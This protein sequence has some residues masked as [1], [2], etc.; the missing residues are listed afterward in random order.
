MISSTNL[1]QSPRVT[2]C[3]LACIV[4]SHQPNFPLPQHEIPKAWT[5]RLAF[6]MPRATKPPRTGSRSWL[7][8]GL[9][10]LLIGAGL[11]DLS[12]AMSRLHS[13]TRDEAHGAFDHFIE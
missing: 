1:Q 12:D 5:E 6:S 2:L 7:E 9:A 8:P 10:L 4:A 3:T 11:A 13:L